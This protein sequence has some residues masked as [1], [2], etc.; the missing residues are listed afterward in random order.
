MVSTKS[1]STWEMLR[2]RL[3][4]CFSVISVHVLSLN[5]LF[6]YGQICRVSVNI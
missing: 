1:H 4:G 3:K 6:N 5:C 2:G